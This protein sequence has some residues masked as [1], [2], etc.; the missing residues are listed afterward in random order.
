MRRS[1]AGYY[2][3]QKF[4]IASEEESAKTQ[5]WGHFQNDDS[6]EQP[7]GLFALND[8]T[9]TVTPAAIDLIAVHG[10]GGHR[11]RTWQHNDSKA[12]WLRDFLP[13][14]L[15]NVR[16]MTYGY[17]SAVA[18]S[19]SIAGI[20]EFARDLL[21][22][23]ETARQAYDTVSRP[24]IF[25]CHSICGLVVKKDVLRNGADAVHELSDKNSAVLHHPN[26][27][28]VPT[29]A[30]HRTI[31]QFHSCECQNYNLVEGA[32]QELCTRANSNTGKGDAKP[33]IDMR[34]IQQFHKSDYEGYKAAVELPVQNTCVW[35]LNEY[36]YFEWLKSSESSFL[37]ISG[38]PGCG[39]TTL[40]RFLVE[41][42]GDQISKQGTEATIC[43]YFF[44]EKIKTQSDGA[45][46]LLALIHQLLRTDPELFTSAEKHLAL[47]DS[48]LAMGLHNLW[49][50]LNS[51]LSKTAW[52]T[53]FVV[54]AL[55]E[56]EA[57]S[58]SKVVKWLSKHISDQNQDP[59]AGSWLKIVVTSR[60]YQSIDD[61]FGTVSHF[62]C[63]LGDYADQTGRDIETF[64]R[65]RSARIQDITRCP[66]NARLTI[67]TRLLERCDR[68]FLWIALVLDILENDSDSSE[69]AYDRIFTD[70][71]E[72]LDG[73]Y[74]RIL[75]RSTHPEALLRVLSIIAASRRALTLSEVNSALAVRP[76]DTSRE[77]VE[78]RRQFDISRRLYSICGPFIR[79]SHGTVSFIHQTAKEFLIRPPAV[80]APMP[81]NRPWTYKH[82]LELSQVNRT[83]AEICTI[84]L[85]ISDLGEGDM[86]DYA[87]KHW[88]AHC[89]LGDI[90]EH[91]DLFAKARNLC[92]TSTVTFRSW[93]QLYWNTISTT[94]KFPEGLTSL[95]LTSHFGLHSIVQCLLD[96][97][98]S[99]DAQ[100][101][102]GWAA[103]HWAVWNGQGDK[104]DE[105]TMGL[106][107]RP[108][109]VLDLQDKRGLTTLHWAAADGQE[110]VVKLLLE[111]G[112]QV[113]ILDRDGLTPLALAVEN[114]FLGAVE[115]L[116]DY[117]AD[118]NVAGEYDDS[119]ASN[120]RERI[121]DDEMYIQYNTNHF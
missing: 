27:I 71:P 62:R 112:A 120:E 23:L 79:V 87:A 44:D 107:L 38:D 92:D 48:Q 49:E 52:N 46:L 6:S 96:A 76:G 41:K 47:K 77:Q 82:C 70:L 95:M 98:E 81:V 1:E 89:R 22:R 102:E 55:D 97:G 113:D 65:T 67:E 66:D 104:I 28:A 32:I 42:I 8:S 119:V 63:S 114:E 7:F 24:V 72:E 121:H 14:D 9:S 54:D 64:I 35:F 19:K 83:L 40:A 39:K 86:F 106:L 73:I 69:E 26:E 103:M 17:N 31:C 20:E 33:E 109:V 78:R 16:I 115:L 108:G 101:S 4:G 43:H 85:A 110:G 15:P 11:T 100:D 116:L 88:G 12:Y 105:A 10:L 118:I 29:R 117:G 111:A 3:A 30:N 56:C 91:D 93:F 2:E 94:P 50:I 25:V 51:M 60:R 37:W 59:T 84:S 58:M 34:L 74:G 75:Q 57:I 5:E 18:F 21:E 68:T 53:I 61:I 99:V 90:S 13:S 36:N 45:S 80:P